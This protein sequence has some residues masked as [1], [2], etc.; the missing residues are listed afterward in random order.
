M[1]VSAT[2]QHKS[3]ICPLSPLNFPP[4]F[5]PFHP[6]SCHWA[7][8]IFL[9][10]LIWRIITLQYCI[11]FC[12]ITTWMSY[13]LSHFSHVRLFA[14]PHSLPCSSV[15]GMF[16]G[17]NTGVSCRSSSR[18]SSQL[19]DRTSVSCITSRFFTTEPPGRPE[20]AICIRISPPYWASLPPPPSH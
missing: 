8:E 14:T 20:L 1:L 16:P 6:L 10:F 12:C 5:L 18:G 7:S 4:T 2:H 15:Y 3:A 13:V 9:F 17:K 19:R 11:S